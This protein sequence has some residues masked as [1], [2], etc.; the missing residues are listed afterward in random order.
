MVEK[1]LQGRMIIC[2]ATVGESIIFVEKLM[3]A[4]GKDEVPLIKM[5]CA[6]WVGEAREQDF[7]F[8]SWGQSITNLKGIIYN[9]IGFPPRG[10]SVS[11][12]E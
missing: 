5:S 8:F 7:F 6:L 4:M 10:Q 12:K 11:P 3:D 1:N 9:K 2:P